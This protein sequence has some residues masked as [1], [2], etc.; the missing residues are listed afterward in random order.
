MTTIA[1]PRQP[2]T[3]STPN[4][5]RD[6]LDLSRRIKNSGLMDRRYGWYLARGVILA[7][8]FAGATALLLT[9]GSSPWQLAVA[10]LFGVLFTQAAFLR[11]SEEHTSE[12]PSRGPL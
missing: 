10:A 6:F 3:R 5:Q 12:L 2:R 11:R 7:A 8:G 1:E 9:L 4:P